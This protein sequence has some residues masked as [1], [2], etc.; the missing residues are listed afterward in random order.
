V[1]YPAAADADGDTVNYDDIV[2][3]G[4]LDSPPADCAAT[5]PVMVFSHG[6]GGV[7]FQ[8]IFW[9][10]FL[11]T[12]GWVVIAPDHRENTL[13]DLD[14]SILLEVAMRRPLEV[15]ASF[16]WLTGTDG[17]GEL[18]GC[19]DASEGYAVSGHSFGAYT[20]VVVT[21]TPIDL[22]ASAA[23]CAD[24]PEWLCDDAAAWAAAHPDMPVVDR[25]DPRARVGVAMT[26]AGYEL[27][28][29]GLSQ[30]TTD[31]CDPPYLA[32]E[33]AHLTVR[34]ASLAFL[35]R[36]AGQAEAEAWLP[37]DDPQL[38]WEIPAGR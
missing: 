11:A 17:G 12:H 13:Y 14:A 32:P 7:R 9:T 8:S 34:A 28:V 27:L 31:D 4:A 5:R 37:P 20:T 33:D 15:A 6:N 24:H 21:G 29:G 25:A 38:T 26:P 16:D 2:P 19:L 10:E 30:N 3:G 1:W 22:A 18:A 35:Q 23:W 36:A